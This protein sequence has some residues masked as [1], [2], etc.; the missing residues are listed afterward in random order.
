L[1]TAEATFAATDL[2]R[3][4]LGIPGIGGSPRHGWLGKKPSGFHDGFVWF[5]NGENIGILF[6]E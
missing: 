1:I 4:G 3:A 2:A 6:L 5:K